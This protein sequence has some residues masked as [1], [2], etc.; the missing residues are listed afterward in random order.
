VDESIARAASTI[1]E[2][3]QLDLVWEGI[4]Q[5]TD[6]TAR[7]IELPGHDT[8]E[9][10]PAWAATAVDRR[11]RVCNVTCHASRDHTQ[12]HQPHDQQTGHRNGGS[13]I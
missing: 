11:R 8:D 4:T 3:E 1:P 10:T 9:A 6:V 7:E 12:P 2:S 13:R 5:R